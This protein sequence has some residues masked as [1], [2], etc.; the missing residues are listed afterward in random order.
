VSSTL[1][2]PHTYRSIVHS[3]SHPPLGPCPSLRRRRISS[4]PRVVSQDC[5]HTPIKDHPPTQ[6]RRI[7]PPTSTRDTVSSPLK[8]L[9][10][11]PAP[12]RQVLHHSHTSTAIRPFK[13]RFD[14]FKTHRSVSPPPSGQGSRFRFTSGSEARLSLSH[15]L[16]LWSKSRLVE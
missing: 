6:A 4:H 13:S 5:S 9:P 8:E 2:R 1:R 10:P 12:S 3:T 14:H 7:R 11:T 16:V 15:P